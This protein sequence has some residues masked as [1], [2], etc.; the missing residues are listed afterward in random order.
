MNII[1]LLFAYL[2]VGVGAEITNYKQAICIQSKGFP[3]G[4]TLGGFIFVG[5]NSYAESIKPHE[6]GHTIQNLIWGPLFLFVI[7]LPSIIR[8]AYFNYCAEHKP[9][10]YRTMDYESA[11]FEAQATKIGTKYKIDNLKK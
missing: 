3:G 7:G 10:K 8:A 9:E 1:G 2:M 5:T 11:W 6:Y 4:I